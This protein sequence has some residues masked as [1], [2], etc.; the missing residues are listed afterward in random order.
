M[1]ERRLYFTD[2]EGSPEGE[3]HSMCASQGSWTKLERGVPGSENTNPMN[4]FYTN[5][6][7]N[8]LGSLEKESIVKIK[9]LIHSLESASPGQ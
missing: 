9:V 6:I 7:K 8:S 4:I 1:R 3:P 2:K 5:P